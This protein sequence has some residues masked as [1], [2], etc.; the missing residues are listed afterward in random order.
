MF[1]GIRND[2]APWSEALLNA[3]KLLLIGTIFIGLIPTDGL[4]PEHGLAV[5]ST[6]GMSGAYFTLAGVVGLFSKLRV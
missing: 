5:A 3:G 6:A 4:V 2:P 1:E